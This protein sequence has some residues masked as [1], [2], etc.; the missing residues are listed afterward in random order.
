MTKARM[1]QLA[2]ILI[3]ILAPR[4]AL[5]QGLGAASVAG[6]VKDASGAVLPGVTVEAASPV[7]IEKVRTTVTDTEGRYQLAELRAGTY[8]LTFTLAGFTTYKREGLQLTP[9]FAA[10]INADLKVGEL[11]ETIVVSGQSPL[12][13]T[14]SVSKAQVISQETLSALPT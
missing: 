1:Q 4:L 8:T 6:V 2:L 7:L 10:T 11:S 9:N 5:A 12:V 3:L 13:D 14:R